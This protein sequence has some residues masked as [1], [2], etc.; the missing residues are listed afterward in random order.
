MP[1]PTDLLAE[2]GLDALWVSRP[3]H[4]RLLSGFSSP[5]DAK[6][7]LTR[8]GATLY[9]DARYSV[10][11]AQESR[12]A[13]FIG[14]PPRANAEREIYAHATRQLA[15][16]TLGFEADHLT[17][18][19]LG[20]LRQAFGSE[21][22]PTVGLL[23]G[24]RLRKDEGALRAIR[25]AQRIADE[26]YA[27][28]RPGITAGRREVDV[29]LDLELAMR[30]RGA[31]G[32]AF[33]IIVASGERGALPHG[34]ASAKVIQDGEL[35]TIDLGARVDG[36]HSDMTRTFA[37]GRVSSELRRLYDAVREA[38]EACVRRVKSGVKAS[39]L[40]AH[41][42]ELLAERDLAQYFVHSLG[43]GVGLAIHEG[44]G[45]SATSDAVLESGMV[46]TIEPGVYLP[47]VGGVR[48]E[49]LVL[50]TEDGHEVLSRSEKEA[51]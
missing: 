46:I 13:H 26:A 21:P 47:G 30:R 23:E 5:E 17:V 8:H 39:D 32:V 37:V 27:E 44:P 10:Q 6:L 43:H 31:E 40:D 34:R 28:V 25:A 38:E 9:T 12:V 24:L 1:Q 45:L 2:A 19:G 42:R 22:K 3:E 33:E 14:A 15:G 36:Y 41:A 4:V 49:D 50:V 35:V 16:G 29:A 51:V 18:A 48:V 20:A 7:L 11:A